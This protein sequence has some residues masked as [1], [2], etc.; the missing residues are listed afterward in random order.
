M[1]A[2][3]RPL[4]FQDTM[5]EGAFSSMQHDHFFVELGPSLTEMKD[6]LHFS[7]PL[8]VLGPLAEALVLR[9]YM[10]NFL[11]RRNGVLKEIAESELLWTRFLLKRE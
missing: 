6:V 3:E 8:P 9:R 5:I 2:F 1:T 11:R 7:A 4:Y 10:R